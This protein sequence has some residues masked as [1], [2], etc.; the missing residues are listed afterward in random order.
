MK[1]HLGPTRSDLGHAKDKVASFHSIETQFPD[2]T[3]ESQIFFE[4]KR[5]A[6]K[7]YAQDLYTVLKVVI[8]DGAL[9]DE[10]LQKDNQ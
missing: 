10:I 1:E 8:H 6:T 3:M 9:Y 7:I 4:G 2:G 5:V